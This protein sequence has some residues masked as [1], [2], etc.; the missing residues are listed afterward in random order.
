MSSLKIES[1]STESMSLQAWS[2]SAFS[3][4][5]T[6]LIWLIGGVENSKLSLLSQLRNGQSC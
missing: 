2:K 3:Y 5:Q 1:Q 6:H 4:F